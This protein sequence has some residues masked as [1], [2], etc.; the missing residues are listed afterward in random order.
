MAEWQI[1]SLKWQKAALQ[2]QGINPYNG[3]RAWDAPPPA[4]KPA[5]Q[6]IG[7]WKTIFNEQPS[8]PLIDPEQLAEIA[9]T[10]GRSSWQG[11][12][13]AIPP[14]KFGGYNDK[15]STLANASLL[16]GPV[17]S[18]Y[19]INT[20]GE[21]GKSPPG[22]V[23]Y[24][25]PAN[26]PGMDPTTAWG[27]SQ[28]INSPFAKGATLA[29]SLVGL[30]GLGVARGILNGVT[31][32]ALSV[33]GGNNVS[34]PGQTPGLSFT[35]G[36]QAL[37]GFTPS[38]DAM[39]SQA[40]GEFP[41]S[42]GGSAPTDTSGGEFPGG[43]DDPGGSAPTDTSGGE[44]PGGA[45][46]PGG[47]GGGSPG[48]AKIICTEL[49]RQGYMPD[50]IYHADQAFGKRLWRTDPLVIIG[51]HKWASRVVEWMRKSDDVTTIVLYLAAPWAKEMAYR[52]GVRDKGS[53][54]GRAMLFVGIPLCRM[55]GRHVESVGRAKS[56]V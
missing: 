33:Y 54:I 40:A 34:L 43:A 38:T 20:A 30:N 41:G 53:L 3:Q 7:A 46:D 9:K 47:G 10:L 14:V 48:G 50:Y 32:A 17:G 35:H 27:L 37:M 51:Y 36:V 49:H 28:D 22:D 21:G 23:G 12:Q 18:I 1:P 5:S 24:S 29:A 45:D 8:E 39:R 55:I 16:G 44:F 11:N 15:A 13:F 42:M 2:A 56:A 19:D 4:S 6:P 52:M 31:Q 25:A 26:L